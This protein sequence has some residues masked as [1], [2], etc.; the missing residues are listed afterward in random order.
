MLTKKKRSVSVVVAKEK[1]LPPDRVA[2]RK[3]A[4]RARLIKAAYGV[5]TTAGVDAAKI[6]DITDQADV[7]F[8][9]FYNY[10]GTKDEL[11]GR[12]LDCVI[13]DLGRRND[14]ATAR[15]KSSDPGRVMPVS[16]RLVLREA[17]TT[18]MWQWWVLR[19]DL[20]VDRMRV[21]FS[22]FG[23]RDI[24]KAIAAGVYHVD[25]LGV[26]TSWNLAVW[27][28]VGGMRDILVNRAPLKR[29]QLVVEA[30]MRIM[31]V[32]IELAH[33]FC[34]GA[35]PHYPPAEI[36]FG[37]WLPNLEDGAES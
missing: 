6:Q 26:E 10:F 18:P 13:D 20:L 36:D 11:A 33:G 17:L 3:N 22:R 16:I 1:T 29:E 5:M 28:M 9:T 8:G 35:L 14:F 12:V 2:R 32:P 21:G 31:G 25:A 37:F 23:I 7:G 34:S 24:Q 30:I 19:P 27:M 4:T 15:Y